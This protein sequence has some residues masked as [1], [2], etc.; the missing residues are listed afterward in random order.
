MRTE[1]GGAGAAFRLVS[2]CR[3]TKLNCGQT[4]GGVNDPRRTSDG[5]S[6]TLAGRNK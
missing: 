4:N 3:V 2:G 1:I 6:G 5:G